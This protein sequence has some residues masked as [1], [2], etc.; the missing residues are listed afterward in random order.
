MLPDKYSEASKS[1]RF[2]IYTISNITDGNYLKTPAIKPPENEEMTSK[3]GFVESEVDGELN[4]N[5]TSAD[6]PPAKHVK[7]FDKFTYYK[8]EILAG[9]IVG[10]VLVPEACVFAL[11]ANIDPAA[12]AHTSWVLGIVC[13]IFGGRPAMIPGLTGGLASMISGL[14]S[15][16]K[17]RS[18]SGKGVEE[19]FLSTIVAGVII[20]LVGLFKIGKF[21]VMIPATVKVGFC[22]GLAIIIRI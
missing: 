10:F 13:S 14:V 18:G 12:S 7:K 11:I 4:R 1:E 20:M 8:T 15:P 19:F 2:S 6:M 16:E 17:Q 5:F 3:P 21:Q 22:N 9:I